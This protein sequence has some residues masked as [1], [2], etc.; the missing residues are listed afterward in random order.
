MKNKHKT[1]ELSSEAL[2]ELAAWNDDKAAFIKYDLYEG[3]P[4]WMIY[5]ADG[6]RVAATDNRDFAFIVAKQNDLIPYSAH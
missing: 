4:M 3:K 6:E 5:D 2:L 1:I